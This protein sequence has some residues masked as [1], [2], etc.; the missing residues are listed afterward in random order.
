MAQAEDAQAYVY[1]GIWRDHSMSWLSGNKLT[2]GPQM[3]KVLSSVLALLVQ[4]AGAQLWHI[5]QVAV[6][7][8]RTTD[9]PRDPM[10]WMLQV[11]LRNVDTALSAL[12]RFTC[13]TWAWRKRSS[14]KSLPTC[15]WLI[16]WPSVH[17][18]SIYS[19]G[20][21]VSYFLDAGSRML[22]RSPYCGFY[23]MDYVAS[24]PDS[25][26]VGMPDQATVEWRAYMQ[27]R[28]SRTQ[29]YYEFCGALP[30]GCRDLPY[31]HIPWS[32][33][34]EPDCPFDSSLCHPDVQA[35]KFDTGLLSSHEHFGI[36][37]QS[38]D[39]IYFR[40][41]M[42]C[43]PLNITGY[44]T[45]WQD[46]PATDASPARRVV[47][48]Y[49]GPN[50]LADENATY[51]YSDPVQYL[52]YDQFSEIPPY[53]LNIQSAIAGDP[54]LSVSDFSPIA[55]LQRTDA[56]VTLVFLSF[57]KFY[58]DAVNDP[59]FS[60]TKA[61]P[62][63]QTG[64]QDTYNG[65]VYSRE[66]PITATA[67]TEQYQVC[68]NSS[69]SGATASCTELTGY[70]GL[71]N[72]T[73][74][75][76]SFTWNP[77]QR[78]A[79]KRVLQAAADSWISLVL[80]GLAQRDPPLL[81]RRLVQDVVGLRLPDDQWEKEVEYWQ[82]LFMTNM[83]RAVIEYAT[84]QFVA[85]TS[86]V[87]TTRSPEIEWL[88]GNQIVEGTNYLSF[89]FVGVMLVVS[90]SVIIT[91]GGVSIDHVLE[92]AHER[93]DPGSAMDHGWQ[94]TEMLNMLRALLER[95]GK[96]QW[97]SPHGVPLCSPHARFDINDLHYRYDTELRSSTSSIPRRATT[98]DNQHE[99]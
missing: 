40:K 90:I 6:H 22:S 56:D 84:G 36:N 51:V 41:V 18:A 60:A 43:T 88:C 96:G 66:A 69:E 53:Q 24:F 46:L 76:D 92:W 25:R 63:P 58:I 61:G 77:H 55:Q 37:S 70:V 32:T 4:I 89:N 94:R 85:R 71:F 62:Y 42:T 30:S 50:P 7:Q 31:Q 99:V 57:N 48:V 29:H 21:F 45:D 67:C 15:R 11:V 72:G 44:T 27:T 35:M 10:Y 34:R 95:S 5:C 68:N 54:D 91:I 12:T 20:V 13:M 26:T 16:L 74:G 75:V 9:Q 14:T 52:A 39:R 98:V 8:L 83:Q 86:Y 78:V 23:D 3:A 2:L 49:L 28:L 47:R 79:R 82:A 80:S 97:S 65:T 17:I 33:S 93:W 59:W 81:A 38:S 64:G 87:N 19:L 1:V 73:G